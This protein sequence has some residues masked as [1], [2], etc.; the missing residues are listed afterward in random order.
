MEAG[1]RVVLHYRNGK[2]IK[3]HTYDFAPGKERFH[4]AHG[5]D[6]KTV[7]EVSVGELKA[8]FYVAT[9]EGNPKRRRPK[10]FSAEEMKSMPGLKLKVT[11]H[12]GE[13][14]IGT[15]AGW[16]RGRPGFFLTPLDKGDNSQ[17]IWVIAGAAKSIEPIR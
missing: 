2:L 16:S 14:I 17:R 10:A 12:D 7:T 5:P 3:G 1:S 4:I 13:V 8:V 11:F 6:D 9:F 15:T